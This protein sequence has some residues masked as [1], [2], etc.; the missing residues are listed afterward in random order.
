MKF[1]KNTLILIAVT[2]MAAAGAYWFFFS[3]SG[4]QPPLTAGAPSS[5]Q[6]QFETLVGQLTPITF[7]TKIFDDARFRS[8]VDLTTAV[9]PEES[10]RPDPFA[11][12]PGV[13]TKQ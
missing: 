8:L 7:N 6:S 3:G 12:I 11:S 2:I 4:N 1:D 5:A 9:T 13:V 10:G